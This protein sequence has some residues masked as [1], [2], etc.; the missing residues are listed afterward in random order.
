MTRPSRTSRLVP[1]TF[2]L[3]NN[4]VPTTFRNRSSPFSVPDLYFVPNNQISFVFLFL[5]ANDSMRAVIRPMHPIFVQ[6]FCFRARSLPQLSAPRATRSALISFTKRHRALPF[7]TASTARDGIAVNRGQ[8]KCPITLIPNGSKR[9]DRLP[10][11]LAPR[12]GL[13]PHCN[14]PVSKRSALPI[15]G[16][17]ASSTPTANTS[18]S[19]ARS[20]AKDGARTSRAIQ[21][22]P[23]AVPRAP[24]LQISVATFPKS[25]QSNRPSAQT[26]ECPV[27]AG[28]PPRT[29]RCSRS[30]GKIAE[31]LP[32]LYQF[33]VRKCSDKFKVIVFA[34][35][36][37][38]DC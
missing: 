33:F 14:S 3:C 10:M 37:E 29:S 9:A 15:P 32:C 18:P 24:P 27:P 13:S 20:A 6:V 1:L 21:P 30:P 23:G 11:S 2:E 8:A 16:V 31:P 36:T 35:F 22:P 19:P 34:E 17:P 12:Q 28:M 4:P 5:H 26:P 38:T 7:P 25:A